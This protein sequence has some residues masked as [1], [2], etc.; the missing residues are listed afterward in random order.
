MKRYTAFCVDD[1]KE[2]YRRELEDRLKNR[3]TFDPVTGQI[4]FSMNC[5]TL[6]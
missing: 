4:V 3:P 6:K 2:Q 5:F 1:R